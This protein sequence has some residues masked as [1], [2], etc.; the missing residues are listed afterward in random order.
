GFGLAAHVAEGR[1]WFG[2]RVEAAPVVYCAQEGEA[3]FKLR[4]AAWEEFQGHKLPAGLQMM[5]QPFNVTERQDIQDL[6]AVVPAGAVVIID[7]LN[8]AAPGCD[9]NSS[10]DMGLII[11]AAKCLQR[12]T[13]GL[14]VLVHH[15]G[16]DSAKGLRGHSSLFAA[17]DAVLEVSRNGDSREWRIAKSKD[18]A[19]GIAR[20]FKLE[21]VPLGFDG[22]G[23][24]VTSCVIAPDTAAAEMR[25]VIPPKSGNQKVLWDGLCEMLACAEICR[26]ADAPESLPPDTPAVR[27]E[28]AIDTLRERL[29]CDAKRKTERTQQGLTGLQSKGLIRID[30]GYVWL[31]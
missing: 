18:D 11:E 29:A 3:G 31:V 9:E 28:M 30:G 14:V 6:A 5:L 16:K 26:P 24:A 10:V 7:T 20:P 1:R 12:L 13:G 21:V 19:D 27:L 2:Y 23:D 17:L 15:S 25:R 4:A 22:Y 8:R